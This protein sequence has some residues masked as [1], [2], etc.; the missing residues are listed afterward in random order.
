RGE[1]RGEQKGIAKERER[2]VKYAYELFCSLYPDSDR[3]DA[4]AFIEKR[5]GVPGDT[6]QK[7]LAG[8]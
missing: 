6:V 1:R 2:T 3:A 5:F 8:R 7:V 4:V